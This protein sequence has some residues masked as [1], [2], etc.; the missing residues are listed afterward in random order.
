MSWKKMILGHKF[1]K[2]TIYY[3]LFFLLINVVLIN[4]YW[5]LYQDSEQ[6]EQG[7][8]QSVSMEVRSFLTGTSIGGFSY[9][10]NLYFHPILGKIENSKCNE[11]TLIFYKKKLSIVVFKN[12][13]LLS[14]FNSRSLATHLA[15]SQ[16]CT[17]ESCK[18]VVTNKLGY[19]CAFT[20][21]YGE[22]DFI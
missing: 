12:N 7:N 21:S 19:F 3:L 2:T 13:L 4:L 22:Q 18:P 16:Y 6:S 11:K 17:C 5:Q 8:S 1:L 20:L 10:S 15:G 14:V 9:S